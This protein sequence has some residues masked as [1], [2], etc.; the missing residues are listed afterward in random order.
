MSIS[1]TVTLLH[2]WRA[3]IADASLMTFDW[4]T[5]LETLANNPASL[6]G[7]RHLKQGADTTVFATHLR[8]DLPVV[9]KYTQNQ[10][11]FSRIA[12]R[13]RASAEAREFH[14]AQALCQHDIPTPQPLA[15]FERV[16]RTCDSIFITRFIG[17]LRDLD[18][19]VM[20]E[21]PRRKGPEL[22]RLKRALAEQLAKTIAGF[23]RAGFSHRDL[24]ASNMLVQLPNDAGSLPIVRLVDLKGV[25]P[26]SGVYAAEQLR[27]LTRLAAS[28]L[29]YRSLT[30]T[31]YARFLSY[32]MTHMELGKCEWRK[33]Y[34][35][36][37]RDA[38]NYNRRATSRKAGKIDGY[39]S[40]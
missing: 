1:K 37:S 13:I 2:G 40:T 5:W 4:T 32:Y 25:T 39:G 30:R 28:L 22:P 16:G 26:R 9:V 18:Q 19:V 24:K 34:P 14:I 7:Y 31:D 38:H 3:A 29:G 36:L 11:L 12:R 6:P 33:L 15:W 10:G 21:L 20:V 35:T 17:D 8:P 27:A 23:H